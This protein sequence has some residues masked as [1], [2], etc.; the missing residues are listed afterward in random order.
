MKLRG[1]SVLFCSLAGGLSAA[2]AQAVGNITDAP[3]SALWVTKTAT[4]TG[5]D[6]TAIDVARSKDGSVY[7][8]Q[9]KD[10]RLQ[11][12]E[13]V[14]VP[15]ER[16]I[17]SS[18]VRNSCEVTPPSG[19]PQWVVRTVVQQRAVLKRM[20][21]NLEKGFDRRSPE[22]SKHETALGTKVQD[23]MEIFGHHYLETRNKD[24]SVVSEGDTWQTDLGFVVSQTW[25]DHERTSTSVMEDIRRE[26]PDPKL[27]QLPGA[28]SLPQKTNH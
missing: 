24:G 27:F 23:G 14:D 16:R 3:F 11:W 21:A 4:A 9:R 15:N 20:Q 2:H 19:R 18:L 13:I 5:I 17:S 12:I 10:G 8:A 1:W 25:T 26:E 6:F 7:R 22:V 28:C